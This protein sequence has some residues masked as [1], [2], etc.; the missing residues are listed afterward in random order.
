MPKGPRKFHF[1]FDK[2]GLT[3]FG[4]LLLFQQ[5]CKSLS[6]RHFLQLYVRWPHYPYKEY[7]PADLLLAHLFAIVAGIGRI[8]DTQCL[9]H[10]GLIPPILGLSN[11]P[12]RSTLR[13]FLWRFGPKELQGLQVAHDRLRG[14]FFSRLGLLYSAI[15][16]ADTTA[17]ITYGTQ[18]GTAVGYIP[19]RRHRQPSY[20]PLISSEGRSGLSLGMELR[21]GDVHPSRGAWAFLERILEKLPSTIASTRTRLRLDGAFYDR[22]LI[23]SLDQERLGYVVVA[24]MTKPLRQ[25]MVAARYREFAH[26]WEAAEFLYTPFRWNEEHRFVAVR[27]PAALEPEEVQKHLFT[28]KRYTYHRALVTGLELSPP[29]VWRFYCDRGFQELLLREFKDSY[30][31]AKIPTRSYFANATYMEMILWAYDLVLAFQFLCLPQEVQHWNIS[32]LRRELWWLPA[33]WVK[34]GSRNVLGLPAKYPRQDL[35]LKIQKATSRV[36]PLV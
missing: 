36:R 31:M 19:K 2:T 35:F 26:G 29:A 10:N 17:L 28:F 25:R 13:D 9:I 12:H 32:T 30:A 6:L 8:E 11:F 34:R 16:D 4:G 14:E 1:S 15:V 7:H 27:R 21:A 5:F 3:R 20:A 24:K 33:E 23:Q 22:R 18:E